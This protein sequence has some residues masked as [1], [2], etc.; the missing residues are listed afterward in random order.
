MANE[1]GQVPFTSPNDVGNQE[2]CITGELEGQFGIY[3]VLLVFTN[4]CL[5]LTSR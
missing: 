1:L 2:N 5:R 3:L 4:L